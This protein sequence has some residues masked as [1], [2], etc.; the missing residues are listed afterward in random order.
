MGSRNTR[1][2]MALTLGALWLSCVLITPSW[3]VSSLE[4]GQ[5]AYRQGNYAYAAKY[6]TK[7]L[8]EKSGNDSTSQFYLG[9]SL[10]KLDRLSEAREA[11][12]GVIERES[13][14][15]AYG[16]QA[17]TA[18][19]EK[20]RRNIAVIT[21]SQLGAAGKTGQQASAL[22][23]THAGKAD[24]YL[25][26]AIPRGQV[27]HWDPARMPIKIVVESGQGIPGWKPAYNAYALQAMSLWERASGGLVKFKAVR[28]PAQADI[29]VSWQKTFRH[30]QV[31]V[32][33]FQQIGQAIVRADV[34]VATMH[35]AGRPL[36]PQEVYGTMIHELG[37]A[38]GIQ[39]HSPYPGDI[40]Y[41]SQNPV[42]GASLSARDVKTLRLLYAHKADV[43][44]QSAASLSQSRQAY[45]LLQRAQPLVVSAPD[46]AAQLL[47]QAARL[48]PGNTPIQQ[49]QA[50]A[51]FNQGVNALNSGIEAAR[52]NDRTRARTRWQ[53][54]RDYFDRV[55]Q[56]RYAPPATRQNRDAALENL[57][58]LEASAS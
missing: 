34:I 55:L 22:V 33:H 21:K 10:A 52:A 53:Q 15:S 36:S 18:L 57:R 9:L 4:R 40:M 6:F 5:D 31:G 38:L 43:T 49:A 7:A 12:Q 13:L 8:Q 41:F 56:S 50:A 25:V 14:K 3:S 37:H 29:L 46:Q 23:N 32:N 51:V 54:A 48:D 27:I 28:D 47:A 19:L 2:R 35:P 16:Q 58:R 42:Q 1:A 17:N 24:N 39:G 11:F 20:A 30:N 45:A 26:S 44:N